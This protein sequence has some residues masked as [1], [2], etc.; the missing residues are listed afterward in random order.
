M[1]EYEYTIRLRLATHMAIFMLLNGR[2]MHDERSIRNY[3]R[4][5][6]TY[7]D[8]LIAYKRPERNIK[9][10]E[11]IIFYTSFLVG[12]RA[13]SE[14]YIR[15]LI[16]VEDTGV[17][18]EIE[19]INKKYFSEDLS[20]K[21]MVSLAESGIEQATTNV[22]AE[23]FEF[24]PE[25]KKAIEI[26]NWLYEQKDHRNALYYTNEFARKLLIQ[27]RIKGVTQLLR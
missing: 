26:L 21:F 24:M 15:F 14:V 18:K 19:K 10:L 17:R 9:D 23:E 13:Q 7:I 6:S 12:E 4:I 16:S 22:R 11:S 25:D 8:D 27:F 20:R 3:N 5:L 1:R 2:I